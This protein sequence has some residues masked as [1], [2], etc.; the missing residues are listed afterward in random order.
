MINDMDPQKGNKGFLVP[1]PGT[2]FG[3]GVTGAQAG[4]YGHF[5]VVGWASYVDGT[6]GTDNAINLIGPSSAVQE[7]G[8]AFLFH[9]NL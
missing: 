4:G 3:K 6:T 8:K 5:V 2:A 9:R 1:L 7:A